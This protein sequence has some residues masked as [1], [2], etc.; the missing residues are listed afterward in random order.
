MAQ[1]TP[2]PLAEIFPEEVPGSAPESSTETPVSA[3]LFDRL[4]FRLLL[5]GL[6]LP[7]VLTLTATLISS[8]PS[9]GPAGNSTDRSIFALAIG[10]FLFVQLGSQ[11][12]SGWFLLRRP[13]SF[14]GRTL[15]RFTGVLY[16]ISYS[17]QLAW[18]GVILVDL[19]N[20]LG[21]VFGLA[22]MIMSTMIGLSLLGKKR[23]L[24]AGENAA[25]SALPLGLAPRIALVGYLVVAA[26]A[27]ALWLVGHLLTVVVSDGSSFNGVELAYTLSAVSLVLVV[28]LG[29][30]WSHTLLGIAIVALF[31]PFGGIQVSTGG[32][33]QW[34]DAVLLLPVLANAAF[35]IIILRSETRRV[36]LVN[37]FFRLTATAP[38][39]T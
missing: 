2:D 9:A 26:I 37:W 25:V 35:A 3:T 28:L 33:E 32:I 18:L 34:I 7:F 6:L 22:L 13:A 31:A 20:P 4:M 11:V 17:I 39:I 23:L 15:P 10:V 29:L 1:T 19:A 16:A 36:R 27:C 14:Y 24:H 21:L 8:Q 30:P 38:A 12:L 5:P